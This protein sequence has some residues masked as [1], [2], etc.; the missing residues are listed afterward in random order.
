[1]KDFL[2]AIHTEQLLERS[3]A[4]LIK[5]N[6]G[7]GPKYTEVKMVEG[8]IVCYFEEYLTRAEEL[9]IK[10]GQPDKI[11]E[12]RSRYVTQCIGEI[13]IILDAIVKR[14]IKHFF[15]SWIPES[16]LACWT[17]FLD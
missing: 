11:I 7:K 14:K 17:I 13:E 12:F 4:K 5:E 9:I 8:I 2:P 6:T 1:M 16:N 10:S 15:P 3:F